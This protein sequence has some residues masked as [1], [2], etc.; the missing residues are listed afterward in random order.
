MKGSMSTLER[1]RRITGILFCLPALALLLVFVLY[2]LGRLIVGSFTD[3]KGYGTTSNFIGLENYAKLG[4][5]QYFKEMVIATIFYV[6]ADTILKNVLSFTLALSLDKKGKGRVNR[7]VMRTIWYLPA[8]LSGIVTG[9]C[10]HIMYNYNNGIINQLLSSA[11]LEKVNWLETRGL[12]NV[13]IVVAALW[14]GVGSTCIIYLAGLQGISTELYEAAT[15]DGADESQV[16]RH[17]TVPLM[18]PSIT[19]NVMTTSIGAF[20]AYELPAKI[21]V[22]PSESA[23]LI[24]SKIVDLGSGS[25]Y[26][27]GLALAVILTAVITAI[28]LLQLYYL[29]KNEEK[30]G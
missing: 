7:S 5:I 2:P 17:I 9:I 3:W 29:R 25:Y 13:C 19:I 10:W 28:S 27:R 18:A 14:A 22:G 1:S 12:I 16:I 30:N 24:A 4:Q 11:G 26:G 23:K 21:G 15:I 8:L 6:V 20:K